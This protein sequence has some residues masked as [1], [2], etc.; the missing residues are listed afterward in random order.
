VNSH[1]NYLEAGVNGETACAESK[2]GASTSV[3]AKLVPKTRLFYEFSERP[4]ASVTTISPE[5][6]AVL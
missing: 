6:F 2:Q 3:E 4:S 5:A 1:V